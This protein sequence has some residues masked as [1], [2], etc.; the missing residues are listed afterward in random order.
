[1]F[2]T[3]NKNDRIICYLI[4]DTGYVGNFVSESPDG[5]GNIVLS[6]ASLYTCTTDWCSL[7]NKVY[8]CAGDIGIPGRFIT[9]L[10]PYK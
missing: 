6:N 5:H 8:E 7:F 4:D 1:M 10:W 9:L 2:N 3:F